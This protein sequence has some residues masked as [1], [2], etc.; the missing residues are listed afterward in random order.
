LKLL[1]YYGIKGK[2]IIKVTSANEQNSLKGIIKLLNEG[3]NVGL[4]SDAGTPTISD[5]GKL[6]VSGV[7]KNGF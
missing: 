7:L 2:K 4:V 6:I 1:N 3:K 5:P